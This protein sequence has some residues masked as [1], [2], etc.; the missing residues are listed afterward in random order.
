MPNVEAIAGIRLTTPVACSVGETASLH[1]GTL[2]Q[3]RSRRV[4]ADDASHG[5]VGHAD[6]SSSTNQASHQL[7]H[8]MSES[9]SDDALLSKDRR[10]WC[11]KILRT[12]RHSD[13]K[14]RADDTRTRT[15]HS[16]TVQASCDVDSNTNQ[17][18]SNLAKKYEKQ[19]A[20]PDDSVGGAVG[21]MRE[22]SSVASFVGGADALAAA[23]ANYNAPL[24]T[25]VD[26]GLYYS[27]PRDVDRELSNDFIAHLLQHDNNG[28]YTDGKCVCGLDLADSELPHG[29]SMHRST[30]RETE[31]RLFFT[32]P[33]GETSWELPTIVSVDLDP[34]QQDRI[35]QLMIEGQQSTAHPNSSQQVSVGRRFLDGDKRISV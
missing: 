14:N 4:S 7:H 19:P 32:G 34:Q 27:E 13:R 9:Q 1:E 31:G 21:G 24:T 5:E 20:I 3:R 17:S 35:R 29:W 18:R 23:A 15:V 30:E 12:L 6:S 10:N 33:T 8:S 11:R 2:R 28:H 22:N 25:D 16:V 26:T